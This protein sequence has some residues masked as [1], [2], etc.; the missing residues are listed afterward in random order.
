MMLVGC[1]G[2]LFAFFVA[3]TPGVSACIHDARCWSRGIGRC[4][5]A[6]RLNA[7]GTAAAPYL[8][9]DSCWLTAFERS[10]G[11]QGAELPLAFDADEA[12]ISCGSM[13]FPMQVSPDVYFPRTVPS[14]LCLSLLFCLLR[15]AHNYLK[16]QCEAAAFECAYISDCFSDCDVMQSAQWQVNLSLSALATV[17]T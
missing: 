12:A 2:A 13:F 9:Q 17:G 10:I 7:D 1:S 4:I 14:P 15:L 3:G 5:K 6:Q 16:K 8:P 11:L